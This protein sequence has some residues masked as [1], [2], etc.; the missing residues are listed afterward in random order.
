MTSQARS[1]LAY[2]LVIRDRHS[3]LLMLEANRESLLTRQLHKFPRRSP[4]KVQI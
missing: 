1:V 4:P 3:F 2:T